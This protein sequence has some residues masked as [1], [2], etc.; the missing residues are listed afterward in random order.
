MI[1]I[2]FYQGSEG[3]L[4]RVKGR[5]VTFSTT[6]FGNQMAEIEGLRLNKKTTIKEFPE[7][8]GKENWKQ[9]AIHRFKDFLK[10]ME[11]ENEVADYVIYELKKHGYKPRYK[12]REGHRPIKIQ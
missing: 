5:G 2:L 1:D 4:V 3:V 7:L 10:D 9:L 6:T 11:S 12:Q 8:E